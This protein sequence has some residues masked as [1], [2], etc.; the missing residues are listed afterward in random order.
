MHL[1]CNCIYQP[2]SGN[3]T[4]NKVIFYLSLYVL[5]SSYVQIFIYGVHFC[6]VHLI[7]FIFLVVWS[8]NFSM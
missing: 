1:V 2:F 4:P 8:L 7:S 6:A 3:L 5:R